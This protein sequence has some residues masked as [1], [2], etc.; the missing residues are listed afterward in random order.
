MGIIP[1]CR[2]TYAV[3]GAFSIICTF[4]NTSSKIQLLIQF[5]RI[6]S[7]LMDHHNHSK[8]D[9]AHI[10]DHQVFFQADCPTSK[11]SHRTFFYHIWVIRVESRDVIFG[12]PPPPSTRRVAPSTASYVMFCY[13]SSNSRQAVQIND[14]IK[15]VLSLVPKNSREYH[16]SNK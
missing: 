10:G 16:A 12:E 6:Y 2:L 7:F 5:M 3:L 14:R 9:Q 8:S 13:L 15:V 4:I 11:A 1:R